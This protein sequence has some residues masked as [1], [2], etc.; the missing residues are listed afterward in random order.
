MDALAPYAK[1]IVAAIMAAL[2]IIE[3]WTGWKSE[4][5]TEE[6]VITILGILTPIIVFLVPNSKPAAA[7]AAA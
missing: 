2:L 1:A 6:W 4:L 3:A 5:L 7:P